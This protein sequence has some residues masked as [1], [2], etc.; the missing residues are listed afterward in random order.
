MCFYDFLWLRI[1]I[2]ALVLELIWITVLVELVAL[3]I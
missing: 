2:V 1:T 3:G